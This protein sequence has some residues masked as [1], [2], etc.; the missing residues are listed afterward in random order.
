M[1][2]RYIIELS[3][4]GK[5][6]HG[7]QIQPNANTVQQYL[8]ESLSILTQE[9]IIITGA[10]RTD[11]GVHASYYVAHFDSD[12]DL[13]TESLSFRLNQFVSKDLSIFS[14]RRTSD[15]FHAR[16]DALSRTYKY[17]IN[18]KK[19]AFLNNLSYYYSGDLDLEKMNVCSTILMEYSDF[20]S[21]AKLHSDNKTNI[22]KIEKAVWEKHDDYVI[23]TIKADRFLRNMVRAITATLLDVGKG[24][25]DMKEF[26][27]IINKKDNQLASMS[28]PAKGLYLYDI[29]YEGKFGLRNLGKNGVFPF[30]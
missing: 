10:G 8:Q 27:N 15:D 14:I 19:S 13:D 25:I 2:Q 11:T 3:Y 29:E 6:F 20:T 26:K 16:F 23:F 21:F 5:N 24:K 30:L 4:S 7:W 22:C 28:A 18:T 17:I 1:K 12:S 9:E